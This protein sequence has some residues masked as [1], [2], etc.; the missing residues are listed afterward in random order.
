MILMLSIIL[1]MYSYELPVI[2]IYLSIVERMVISL[3]KWIYAK[4]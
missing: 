1:K 4:D 3:L 2:K